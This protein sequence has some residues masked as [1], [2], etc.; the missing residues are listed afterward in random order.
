VG[1]ARCSTHHPLRQDAV[2]AQSVSC[3]GRSC[4]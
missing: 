2:D 3:S 1:V 4:A